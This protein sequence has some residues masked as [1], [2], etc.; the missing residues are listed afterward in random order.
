MVAAFTHGV[1]QEIQG[2]NTEMKSF[3]LIKKK[4]VLVFHLVAG[5]HKL[6]S[7]ILEAMK[8]KTRGDKL[9]EYASLGLHLAWILFDFFKVL[10][11]GGILM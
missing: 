11:K 5:I 6:W 2:M 8:E 1:S 4:Q 3:H 10:E 7:P 9:K